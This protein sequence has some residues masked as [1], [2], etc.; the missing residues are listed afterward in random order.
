VV[1]FAIESVGGDGLNN[2]ILMNIY[3]DKECASPN[4]SFGRL[5]KKLTYSF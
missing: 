2:G 3:S 5:E 4:V 1:G